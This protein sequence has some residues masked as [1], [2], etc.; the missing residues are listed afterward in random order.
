MKFYKCTI[1]A[2]QEGSERMRSADCN[3]ERNTS[4]KVERRN[5]S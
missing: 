1:E 4:K 2:G 5:L 3:F